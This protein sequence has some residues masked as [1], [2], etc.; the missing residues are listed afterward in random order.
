MPKERDTPDD[1]YPFA[2]MLV[3]ELKRKYQ[4]R[5]NEHRME[6]AEQDLFLAGWQVYQD[7]EDVGLAKNRMRDRAKNLLRDAA[8]ERKHEPKTGQEQPR[9]EI[10]DSGELWDEEAIKAWDP[11][12]PRAT[13]RGDPAEEASLNS[14]L[15]ELTD[16]QR[17]IVLMRM[18]G[19]TA[20][21]TADELGMSLRTVERELQNLRKDFPYDD[22]E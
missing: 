17:Q 2:Q 7:E 18:A 15:D 11:P 13:V 20:Q 10:P 8:S 6:D 3:R 9:S 12:D 4:L 14:Y 19:C 16:R 21:E 5:W 22:A 1:L